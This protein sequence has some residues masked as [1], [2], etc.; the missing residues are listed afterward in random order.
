MIVRWEKVS[1]M[2]SPGG[3]AYRIGVNLA[4]DALKR[5]ERERHQSGPEELTPEQD[6]A[7]GLVVRQALAQLPERQRLA[8]ALRYLAD[9]SVNE[10]ATVMR[11]QP[12][13]VKSLC[14]QA[15][16]GL[17]TSP[18]LSWHDRPAHKSHTDNE[19]K[20]DG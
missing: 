18:E 11:C 10:T 5:Q 3:Y 6:H 15:T 20:T 8:V 1:R 9:L 14:H 12:G 17:R 2:S 16:T 13:T 4:K 19:V 7:T